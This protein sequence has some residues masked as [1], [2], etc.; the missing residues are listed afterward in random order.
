MFRINLT[1]VS[2]RKGCSLHKIKS[3]EMA[4]PLVETTISRLTWRQHVTDSR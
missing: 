1:L 2:E 3:N 4:F